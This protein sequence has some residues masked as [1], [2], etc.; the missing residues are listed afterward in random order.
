MRRFEAPSWRTWVHET[1]A[2]VLLYRPPLRYPPCSPANSTE[3][4]AG[5]I[6][7]ASTRRGRG[8]YIRVQST[9]PSTLF[10]TPEYIVD[11]S[12]GST[13]TFSFVVGPGRRFQLAPSS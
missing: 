10:Q 12:D 11:G 6:A 4:S 2:S 13:T 8:I 1:P 3:G 5:S 7:N 9:P